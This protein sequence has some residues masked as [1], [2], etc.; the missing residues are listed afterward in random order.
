MKA[1]TPSL[2]SLAL[3]ASGVAA[4]QDHPAHAGHAVAPQARQDAVHTGHAAS[5]AT[6]ADPHAG[7]HAQHGAAP[8]MQATP[9][10]AG[11]EEVQAQG[12]EHAAHAR[13][14][15]P[16]TDGHADHAMHHDASHAPTA[17]TE[18]PA[19][20]TT[21]DQ[22]ALPA[23]QPHAHNIT[24]NKDADPHQDHGRAAGQDPHAMHGGHAA[25]AED[26]HAAHSGHAGHAA[27]SAGAHAGHGTSTQPQ[28]RGHDS[29]LHGATSAPREPIPVPTAD[30]IAAAFPALHAHSM[31]HAPTFNRLVVFDRLEGWDN[32]HGSGQAWEAQ[33][34][35]GGDIDRLWLRSD[36]EREDSHLQDWSV[37]ALYGRAVSPWWDVV[38]GVRHDGGDGPG[39]TRAAIGVQGLAPYK[40]EIAAT[41]YLGGTRRAE[42][43]FE[44][45]Y[46]LLL[47]NAL[48]LQ[49]SLEIN[50]VAD[51]DRQRGIGS[52]LSQVEAGLR[53]RYQ[54][55]RHV[56]PYIGFVHERSF[57]NTAKLHRDAGLATRESRWVAGLRFWF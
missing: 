37:E 45:E 7:H 44:A 3:A 2:L 8:N 13:H 56:A 40:F 34:W 26:P 36:G 42:L 27:N 41:G 39:L 53:L 17:A 31:Q 30:D 16:V 52:G 5:P 32:A 23:T 12:D 28:H 20:A 43:E 51:N 11:H 50:L 57:G 25:A 9:Q 29:H 55:G 19:T 21:T 15:I 6:P 48:V 47:T 1:L 54:L 35:F 14:A 24:G 18:S 4:A 10:H 33:G 49:P 46:S 22:A 38:A